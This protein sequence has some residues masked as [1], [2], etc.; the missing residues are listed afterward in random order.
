[1]TDHEFKTGHRADGSPVEQHG[2]TGPGHHVYAPDTPGLEVCLASL[3]REL[4]HRV[5]QAE[6]EL[7]TMDALRLE[8]TRLACLTGSAEFVTLAKMVSNELERRK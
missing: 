8:A 1:M 4:A 5:E 7:P 3:A 2:A 6:R